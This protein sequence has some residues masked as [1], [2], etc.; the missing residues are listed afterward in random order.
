MMLKAFPFPAYCCTPFQP[1]LI[2]A[3]HSEGLAWAKDCVIMAIH[4]C[5][6]NGQ[7]TE[8]EHREVGMEAET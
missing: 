1:P 4:W 5:E 2:R 7:M 6:Q 3:V 8:D